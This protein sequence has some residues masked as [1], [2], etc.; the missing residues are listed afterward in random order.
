MKLSVNVLIAII[1]SF[2]FCY[3]INT[4]NVVSEEKHDAN[5]I[6]E[7]KTINEQ[8]CYKRDGVSYLKQNVTLDKNNSTIILECG[9]IK[10]CEHCKNISCCLNYDIGKKFPCYE[11]MPGQYET[12]YSPSSRMM[13]YE[14]LSLITICIL[15][16]KVVEEKQVY[17]DMT[18]QIPCE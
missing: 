11:Y 2:A 4:I 15:F 17:I 10:N 5:R 14:L 12:D 1:T 9:Q 7:V 6:C 16:V 3:A 8:S 13:F 18:T